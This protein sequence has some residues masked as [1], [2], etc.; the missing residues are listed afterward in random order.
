VRN[1]A[2]CKLCCD[3]I[4]SFHRGDYV[5]CKC[6]EIA[7]CGGTEKLEVFAKDWSNFIRMDD[8]G[9]EIVIHLEES[10]KADQSK[11]EVVPLTYSK[12]EYIQMLDEFCQ[13]IDSLPTGARFDAVTH[14]DLSSVL[15]VVVDIFR[16]S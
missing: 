12:S 10:Q 5:T 11:Q 4:E 9:N 1:R 2:K 7:V 16:C 15:K 8:E 3:V 13:K 14:A 6:D